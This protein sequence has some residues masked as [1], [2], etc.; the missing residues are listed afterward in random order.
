MRYLALAA[1]NND[2]RSVQSEL[3]GITAFHLPVSQDKLPH[4]LLPS[5]RADA[6]PEFVVKAAVVLAKL[7][8]A[9]HHDALAPSR[10][11]SWN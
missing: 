3:T 10:I 1:F 9:S 8:D 5:F 4:G 11:R 6:P 7:D 2:N